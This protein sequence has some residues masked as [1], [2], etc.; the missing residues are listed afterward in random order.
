VVELTSYNP[1]TVQGPNPRSVPFPSMLET[2][3]PHPQVKDHVNTIATN[4]M[5]I[6]MVM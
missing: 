5:T 1:A 3:R 2:K 6:G 4:P